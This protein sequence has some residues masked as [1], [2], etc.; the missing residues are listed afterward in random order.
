MPNSIQP[1]LPYG[2]GVVEGLELYTLG[3]KEQYLKDF[4]APPPG[5]HLPK[6]VDN[7]KRYFKTV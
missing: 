3:K 7:F 5:L 4:V 6:S 1:P 2:T